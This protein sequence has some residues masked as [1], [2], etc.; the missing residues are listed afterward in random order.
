MR[1]SET[2]RWRNFSGGI[3][4][5]ISSDIATQDTVPFAM[6]FIF[7][8]ELGLAV[9]RQGTNIVGSQL[10]AGNP[11]L[12][13]TNFR[14]SVGANHALIAAFNGSIFNVA[15]GNTLASSLSSTGKIEFI[16]FLDN[17]LAVN[18][19]DQARYWAGAGTFLTSGGNLDPGNVPSGTK[20]IIEWHDRCYA[21]GQ[22]ANPDRL[23]FSSTPVSGVISWTSSASGSIQIEREDGGG[24]ITGL[25]KVPGY[26]LI[27]KERSLK[28]WNFDSTFPDDL[29][30]IGTQSQKSVVYGNGTVFFFY[31]P[32]GFYA[33]KGGYPIRISKPI[34]RIVDAISSS[35]YENVSG[36]CDG[37]HIY[38]SVGD[39]TIDF[40]FGYTEAHN[41]VVVRYSLDTQEWAVLKYAHE[42]R[43][44]S[45]FINGTNVLTVGGDS[46]G[47][48][49][50]I[51]TGN[52]D[53]NGNAITY[54]LQ[55]P[56]IDFGRREALKEIGDRIIVHAYPA[57]G[58]LLQARVNY[59]QWN[60]IGSVKGLVS[61]VQL[62]K[63]LK[64]NVFEFRVTESTT[65]AQVSLR[66]LD[67]PAVNVH[68]SFT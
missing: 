61:E 47:Q 12:G 27:F 30:N 20:Y 56:E 63:S 66:G 31:G 60:T 53:Y 29:V 38:W 4:T 13:L 51:N 9:S 1:L 43:A 11:C 45:S 58:A 34:Q 42:F 33:T 8:K 41:N 55:S 24:T 2:V 54:I 16:T 35:Y 40:G 3:L 22:A 49:L 39:L 18:G 25:G 6:N 36:W 10:S 15:N 67:F 64:G 44:W 57:Q 59:G 32:K 62:S 7:D 5:S 23:N 26:L 48:V 65:G 37:E 52:S 14:D 17:V 21:A 19:V 68:Q 50:Q 28:R 46:D